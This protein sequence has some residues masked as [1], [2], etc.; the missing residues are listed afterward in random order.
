MRLGT[1]RSHINRNRMS[2][3][4]RMGLAP[5]LE[6]PVAPF[7]V[8]PE[9]VLLLDPLL[10]LI[11]AARLVGLRRAGL[12][13]LPGGLLPGPCSALCDFMVSSCVASRRRP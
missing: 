7:L 1:P 11:A 3:S 4:S 12:A 5:A 6:L 8:A 10:I 2:Y 13:A 9:P